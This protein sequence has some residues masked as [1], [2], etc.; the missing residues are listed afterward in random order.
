MTQNEI[1]NRIAELKMEY[2]RAQDDLEKLESVGRSG[3]FAQ[4]RLTGIEE[5]LSEL[6]KMEE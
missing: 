6:R 1:K 3:E 2:I 4:K 5:E